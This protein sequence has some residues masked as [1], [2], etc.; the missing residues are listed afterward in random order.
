MNL[1]KDLLANLVKELLTRYVL[2]RAK[3]KCQR[4][5]V[6]HWIVIVYA[7]SCCLLP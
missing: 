3:E 4:L 6:R 2:R 7:V 1:D 5:L